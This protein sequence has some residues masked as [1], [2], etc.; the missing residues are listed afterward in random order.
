M[1]PLWI[2]LIAFAGLIL[3]IAALL[4]FGKARIRI[5]AREKVKV[6]A[7]I[8]GVPL[9]LF[10]SDKK[11]KKKKSLSRCHNPDRVLKK[12]LKRRRKAA[13]VAAKK[14]EKAKKKAAKKALKKKQKKEQAK[15]L[16][17]PN[18]KENLEMV[19]ALL[20]KLHRV[21]KGKPEIHIR[22]L[23]IAVGTDD[24]A[25]TALL[26]GTVVQGAAYL[27]H[28]IEQSFASI[29]RNPDDVEIVPDYL[30]GKCHAEVDI[31]CSLYLSQILGIGIKM[32]TAY[33]TERTLAL[34]KAKKRAQKKAA[35][36]T[37]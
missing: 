16:P 11:E 17:A 37:V 3:L 1:N 32:L 14:R 24:A 35:A 12:E 27:L 6:V 33:R 36:Q 10:N 13:E 20:K 7:Y 25:K 22:K 23:K 28:W 19:A 29:H 26:Y 31:S 4:I 9:T 2:I 34:K 30:S 21:T 15:A 5:I 8:L 18:L